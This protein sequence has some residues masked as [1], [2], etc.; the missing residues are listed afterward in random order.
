MKSKT[1]KAIKQATNLRPYVKPDPTI[2]ASLPSAVIDQVFVL[3]VG[4]GGANALLSVDGKIV[5]YVDL[6]AG[7]LAD[8]GTWPTAMTGICLVDDPIVILTHWHYDHFQAANVYPAAKHRTWIAPLQVLGPG[9][10]SAMA[11][12]II[13]NGTLLVWGGSGSPKRGAIELERSTGPSGNLNR[14]GIA[15]W[16]AG[17]SKEDL[18]QFDPN[19]MA[20]LEA[21]MWRAYYDRKYLE[22]AKGLYKSS[23]HVGLSP[24]TCLVIAFQAGRGAPRSSFRNPARVCKRKER[25]LI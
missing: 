6:G 3:D 4:Q 22:L 9:P 20:T 5:A 12:D 16:I 7:V 23:R 18:T 17:P 2:T 14:T 24:V 21:T 8:T 15:V 1:R 19:T 11:N 13:T 25:C 10:Q